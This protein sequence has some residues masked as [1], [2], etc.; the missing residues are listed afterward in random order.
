MA[1]AM[2]TKKKYR[3]FSPD[4]EIQVHFLND[5][6][7]AI[8]SSESSEKFLELYAKAGLLEKKPDDWVPAQTMLD[9]CSELEERSEV[10]VDFV[11]TGVQIVLNATF[12]PVFTDLPLQQKLASIG[13]GHAHWNRGTDIG[14]SRCEVVGPQHLVFHLRTPWPDDISLGVFQGVCKRFVPPEYGFEV[15]YDEGSPRLDQG[16]N[17]TLIH[18]EWALKKAE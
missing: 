14:Y 1:A 8:S 3:A 2:T 11:A 18:V 5:M 10:A 17:E 4:H 15:Y 6:K 7:E 12:P 13:E 9:I 16:G